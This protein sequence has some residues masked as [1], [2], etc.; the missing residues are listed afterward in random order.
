MSD[1]KTE[2][3]KL[4]EEQLA[5]VRAQLIATG[6]TVLTPTAEWLAL[7]KKMLELGRKL[8]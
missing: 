1:V 4:A 7:R 8:K 3:R 5:E 2:E 6:A